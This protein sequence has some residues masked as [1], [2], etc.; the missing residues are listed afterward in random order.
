MALAAIPAWVKV[1]ATFGIGVASGAF[2]AAT[3]L[4]DVRNLATHADAVAVG[5]EPRIQRLELDAAAAHEA[6]RTMK[7]QMAE[8]RA[9]VKELL[10]R[11]K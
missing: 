9:D 8:V 10:R 3:Y 2:V 4:S 6:T 7:E 11:V 5:H 1:W